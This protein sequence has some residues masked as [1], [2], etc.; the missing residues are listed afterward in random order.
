[1]V[2]GVVLGSLGVLCLVVGMFVGFLK[3]HQRVIIHTSVTNPVYHKTTGTEEDRS[4]CTIEQDGIMFLPQEYDYSEAQNKVLIDHDDTLP[5]ALRSSAVYCFTCP[6]CQAEYVGSTL[7][8]L[9]N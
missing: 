3:M 8:S 7:R 5:T 6:S 2:L 4:G 9:L 1:M